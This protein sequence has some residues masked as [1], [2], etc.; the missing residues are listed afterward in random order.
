MKP[1]LT[2]V[3]WPSLVLTK[4]TDDDVAEGLHEKFR[5]ELRDSKEILMPASSVLPAH[6][7]RTGRF[8]SVS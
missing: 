4:E 2:S 3:R 5:D 6:A 1:P 8:V 7:G